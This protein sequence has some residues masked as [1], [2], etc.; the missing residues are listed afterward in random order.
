MHA[1][2]SAGTDGRS[3]R[4]QSGAAAAFCFLGRNRSSRLRDTRGWERLRRRRGGG[5]RWS[6]GWLRVCNPAWRNN[7]GTAIRDAGCPSS[8][9]AE[10]G[11]QRGLPRCTREVLL[12]VVGEQPRPAVRLQ[13]ALGFW[14]TRARSSRG[15]APASPDTGRPCTDL[16]P[17]PGSCMPVVCALRSLVKFSMPPPE[18]ESTTEPTC[19]WPG[20][21]ASRRSTGLGHPAGPPNCAPEGPDPVRSSS[22]ASPQRS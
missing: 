2:C 17:C 7:A 21:V 5:A 11:Q 1:W 22:R 9:V 16:P 18:L 14:R 19:S 12:G 3:W 6:P 8:A 13:A 10:A 20:A 4:T 15:R